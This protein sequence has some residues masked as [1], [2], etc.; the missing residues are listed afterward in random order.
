[1]SSQYWGGGIWLS[2]SVTL[3]MKDSAIIGNSTYKGGGVFVSGYAKATFINTE[4][5]SNTSQ[6]DGGAIYAVSIGDLALSNDTFTNNSAIG[7]GGAVVIAGAGTRTIENSSFTENSAGSGG[8][9]SIYMA[10]NTAIDIRRN[11]FAT[12]SASGSG[13]ALYLWQT[14]VAAINIEN[15]TFFANQAGGSGGAI[16]N[17]A[18]PTITSN[19]FS[20]NGAKRAS[21]DGGGSIYFNLS[22]AEM[23]NNILA[24]NTGGGEC[25]SYGVNTHTTGKKNLVEDNSSVCV[26]SLAGDPGLLPLGNNGGVTQTMA[27]SPNSIA[28]DAGDDTVCPAT[29]QRGV[30]R[31]IG[32]HCDIGAFEL[33]IASHWVY[34]PTVIK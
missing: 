13:G 27:L 10:D 23:N 25:G 8:A 16:Y 31:P 20:D 18:G 15:N 22:G 9:I 34:F 1:M 28:R 33:F 21:G 32:S 24:N 7:T 2:T 3:V 6:S 4:F 5:S 12:N 17:N 14:S 19:T 26:H 30:N 11:L 29:D